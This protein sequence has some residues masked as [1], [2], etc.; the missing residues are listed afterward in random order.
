M[1][2]DAEDAVI[3]GD[4]AA[5]LAYATPAGGAVATA[6]APVGIRDRDAATVTFTTSL[7]FGRKLER[8]RANPRVALAYHAR[9]H[10]FASGTLFV[11]LQG[12]ATY[13]AEPSRARLE[14]QVL[15]ASVRFLGEP[16]RGLFWDRWLSA[17]Y[18]DRVLVTVR[19]ERVS[20]WPDLRRAGE[21]AVAGAAPAAEPPQSQDPP[22]NGTAPRIDSARAARRLSRLPH[23]LAAW[24]GSDGYPV[25]APVDVG[26]AGAHGIELAGPLPPGARRAG[27]LGHRFEPQ[28]IGLEARQHTGWLEEGTYAPHTARGF[29][30]PVNKTLLLLAN[31]FIARRGLRR[32]QEAQAAGG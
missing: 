9:E 12:T 3:G 29:R 30:A 13:D 18:A 23:V 10:G 2:G 1:W 22:A 31:G 27:L 11:L 19:V 16:K 5:A 21:P 4:L 32:A 8:I 20:S 28:L 24:V 26:A 15:P 7:G 25:V 17:Y 14:E 6:V